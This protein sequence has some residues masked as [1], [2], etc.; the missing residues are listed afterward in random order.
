MVGYTILFKLLLKY[1]YE[2]LSTIKMLRYFAG[3]TL[4]MVNRDTKMANKKQEGNNLKRNDFF[5]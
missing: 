1:L 5:I 3:S 4:T 2:H